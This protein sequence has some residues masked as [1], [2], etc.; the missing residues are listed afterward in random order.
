MREPPREQRR[1]DVQVDDESDEQRPR[2]VGQGSA[3]VERREAFGFLRHRVADAAARAAQ[4]ERRRQR[5]VLERTT[6]PLG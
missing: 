1:V 2:N 4:A 3:P 5:V 6:Q